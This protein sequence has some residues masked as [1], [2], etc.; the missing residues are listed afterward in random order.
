MK[1]LKTALHALVDE[2]TD[3][4]TRSRPRE[5]DEVEQQLLGQL[6]RDGFAVLENYW[7]RQEALAMRDQLESYLGSTEDCDLAN[8]AYLRVW[9]GGRDYDQGV[10]RIYHVDKL[11]PGL[12]AHR[13]DPS[14]MRIIHAYYRRPFH[15]RVLVFQHN[16]ATAHNTRYYH[17]DSFFNELKTFLYLDDVD[18]GNGPFTYLKG[19]HKHHWLRTRKLL[20]PGKSDLPP[21]TFRPEELSEILQ[22]EVQLCGAAG[23]L[24]LA[25]VRG[26]HRGSPQ[27]ERS[28]SVLVNFIHKE[29][30]DVF[31]ER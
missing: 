10:R 28:R 14:L 12:E 21:T 4:F 1:H 8:G 2:A 16:L 6:E 23:T 20:R 27:K 7:S 26:F 17:V 31:P 11:V 22:D 5:L 25:D 18:A 9:E 13:N 15:S 3:L 29:A 24:I 19:S 30:G